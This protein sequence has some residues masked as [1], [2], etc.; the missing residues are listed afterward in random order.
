MDP[1]ISPNRGQPPS[2]SPSAN[3]LLRLGHRLM[4]RAVGTK[5]VAVFRERS[6]PSLLQNLHHRLLDDSVQ[7][8]GDA[9]LSH[10]SVRLGD[11]HPFHRLRLVSPAQQ[12]LPNNWPSALSGI[13][14]NCWTVIP[15][16]PGLPLLALTRC[17]ACLTFSRSHHLLHHSSVPAGLSVLRFAVSDSVPSPPGLGAS[18]LGAG[19][20]AT[21]HLP[22]FLPLAAH[23]SRSLTC[24]FLY[25][26]SSVRAFP[27]PSEYYALC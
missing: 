12:L 23:E 3:I 11:L 2:G 9:K 20:K 19:G 16:T 26:P 15:S 7:H 10:P 14:G 8:R 24:P 1:R 4:R 21:F 6:V 18:L 22:V 25:S 13:P 27:D 17:N 5:T